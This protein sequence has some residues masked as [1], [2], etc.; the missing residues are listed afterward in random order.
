MNFSVS[1]SL[2]D[3][4]WLLLSKTTRK[5]EIGVLRLFS[6]CQFRLC[7]ALYPCRIS[8][9]HVVRPRK[10][11]VP[12]QSLIEPLNVKKKLLYVCVVCEC[13]Y[14]CVC[15][16]G[17]ECKGA[18]TSANMWRSEDNFGVSPLHCVIQGL[19]SGCLV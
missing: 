12:S 4:S 8:A 7:L 10:A 14:V 1:P 15:M 11:F 6:V 19:N 5:E 18:Y 2:S 13:A 17:C 16:H 3:L 9:S